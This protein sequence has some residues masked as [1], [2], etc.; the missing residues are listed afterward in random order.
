MSADNLFQTEM[1]HIL[2]LAAILAA[3][4]S[5]NGCAILSKTNW[6][7]ELLASAALKTL[8]ATS[9]TDAQIVALSA[10]SA[11]QMDSKATLDN[12]SYKARL[13]KV[14]T[15]VREIDGTPLNFQVYRTNEVN[16]FAMADGTIRVYSGLMDVME[17]DELVAII[18]HEIGHVAHKDSKKAMKQA[19]LTSAARD[20]IGA[21]GT[22]GSLS[23]TLLGDISEA[24]IG[25]QYSQK[26]EYV[27][28]EYGF[29]FAIDQGYS[30]YSMSKAL[31][32][33]VKLSGSSQS[34]KVAKM[35]STHPDSAERAERMRT[36]AD[37]LAN[38]D[39]KK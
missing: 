17:D 2:R 4:V 21:A 11:K 15:N 9:I 29:Q 23:S 34:S 37:S 24:F 26:Q 13:A 22:V 31:E 7:R 18:G 28:D 20:L 1:K 6:N 27:A 5:L 33:L 38:S 14:L 32:K 36:K 12:G 16:A 8:S 25:A 35:F 3:F 19:Y 10:Q 30:P 39:T